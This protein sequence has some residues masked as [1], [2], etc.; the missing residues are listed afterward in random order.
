MFK[1]QTKIN[2]QCPFSYPTIPQNNIFRNSISISQNQIYSNNNNYNIQISSNQLKEN[3]KM[4]NSPDLKINYE[5]ISSSPFKPKKFKIFQN[6]NQCSFEDLKTNASNSNESLLSNSNSQL[7]FNL[8]KSY[9]NI[10]SSNL[11][12]NNNISFNNL[13]ICNLRR[14]NSNF[15]EIFCHKNYF[16]N[17]ISVNNLFT[18]NINN[19]DNENNFDNTLFNNDNSNEN[20]LNDLIRDSKKNGK[21][22]FNK[23]NSM[24]EN[25]SSDNT[26]ILTIRIK[27]SKNDYRIF[28]LKKYDDLFISIQKFF[29]IN[30]IKYELIRPTVIKI[31]STLNKIFWLCN[32]KIGIYDQKYL[33]TLYKIWL[34]NGQKI[35]KFNEEESDSSSL[36]EE[37]K[38][39]SKSYQ[40]ENSLEN[41]DNIRQDTAKS[42]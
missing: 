9:E 22:H 8:R 36:S 10:Q 11:L 26:V 16:L 18:P 2:Q 37:S 41:N 35:P 1:A 4:L 19:F 14:S 30:K 15:N 42:Y 17:N 40:A 12:I 25:S 5:Q 7:T 34:K 33:K 13:P 31:F 24:K 21:V 27:V 23:F 28:N 3:S 38:G 20:S 29:D 6:Y 39:E 32:S